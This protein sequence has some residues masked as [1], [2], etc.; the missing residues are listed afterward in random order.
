MWRA[1]SRARSCAIFAA[2]GV[3]VLACAATANAQ[4]PASVGDGVPTGQGSV[5]MFNYGGYLNDGRASSLGASPPAEFTS[6]SEACRTS[7]SADCRRERLE[8]LFAFLA[9]KGVTS[10]EMFGHAGFPS[11]TDIPALQEYRALLDKYGLHAGG[12]HGSMSESGWPSRVE[13]ARI[14]GAD[15]IGS[16]GVG[17]PGIGSYANTLQTAETLNRLGKYAVE[18]GVGP[19]Y[20]HNHAGE[21]DAQY[22]HNGEL[23]TAFDILMAETDARY[24]A[25][26]LDVF[27]SSD[28]FQDVTGEDS[29]DLIDKWP[30]RI[31]ML[32]MKDGVN[33]EGGEPG[34]TRSGN[35][36][37]FGT[38]EIDFRPIL[39]A[40]RNRVHYY[41][42]EEDSG[43]LTGAD[44]SLTNLKGVGPNVV[45]TVQGVP[46]RFP[47][48][49]AGTAAADNMVPVTLTNVG[50][51]PLSITNIGLATSNNPNNANARR[52]GESP[53]D[54]SIVSD[55]CDDATL[56]AAQPPTA[57]APGGTRAT[58]IVNIGFKPTSTNFTSIT[59]L[60]VTSGSD[61]ATEQVLLTGVST[62]EA[63]STVGGEV[64]STLSLTLGPAASFGSFLPATARTYETAIAAAVTSTAG[65]AMLT[66]V[67]PSSTAPGHLVNGTYSLPASLQVRAI[68]AA[69]TDNAFVPLPETA[70][71]PQALLTYSGPS[72]G[73]EPATIGFRQA[74]GA[75]DVLRAG[76][77]SKTL[78]FTLS[79]TTP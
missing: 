10:I 21:F 65:D 63:L 47:S 24:V 3:A 36:E 60:I 23:M 30:S 59:R 46:A 78:T 45:G 75:T 11:S 41:H 18:A 16:G 55:T 64:P 50:D 51:A 67:D 15:Y 8:A 6:V 48:V 77:Y 25:A 43:T 74:I 73:A 69:D 22:V 66:V 1:S 40:A 76:S 28:A 12:W 70:G 37:P 14:L 32:H 71:T 34:D 31:Q 26:E 62:G 17:S 35:P 42:Q 61:A 38:G 68:S 5:Q 49:A 20:I 79:T 72:A 53:G 27:W 39:D 2:T 33:V 29:A 13:A 44:I 4:R 52:E 9:R 58:C 19:V 57:G 56:P 7:T 54:F